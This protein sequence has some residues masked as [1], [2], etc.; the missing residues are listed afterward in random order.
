M[1]PSKTAKAAHRASGRDPQTYELISDRLDFTNI[2]QGE[3]ALAA[4]MRRA[5]ERKA[6]P[7]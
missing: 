4:A 1:V 3:T 7:E 2:K 5:A 6:V